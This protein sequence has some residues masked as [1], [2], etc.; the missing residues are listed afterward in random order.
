LKFEPF[1]Q[2]TLDGMRS[3]MYYEDVENMKYD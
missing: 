1:N 2:P 3:E